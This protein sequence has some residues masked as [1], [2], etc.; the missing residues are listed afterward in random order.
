MIFCAHTKTFDANRYG[1]LA[2]NV[3]PY[4]LAIRAE[5]SKTLIL[6]E[7]GRLCKQDE[8]GCLKGDGISLLLV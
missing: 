6:W 3:H 2:V 4:L 7:L 1:L 8:K 5:P